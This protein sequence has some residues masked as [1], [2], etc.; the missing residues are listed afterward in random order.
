M[1]SAMNRTIA[2]AI[3]IVVTVAAIEPCAAADADPRWYAVCHIA[4]AS[5]L[6]VLL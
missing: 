5:T 2:C 6:P 3:T 4:T 1:T